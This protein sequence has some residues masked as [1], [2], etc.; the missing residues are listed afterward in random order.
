MFLVLEQ[1]VPWKWQTSGLLLDLRPLPE[2]YK[3]PSAPP[4]FL[5]WHFWDTENLF[6]QT[7]N[8]FKIYTFPL[9]ILLPRDSNSMIIND[10]LYYK[11]ELFFF[12]STDLN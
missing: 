12:F 11:I 3:A 8:S 7:I 2:F 10:D 1:L 5:A 4:R 6:C 9:K